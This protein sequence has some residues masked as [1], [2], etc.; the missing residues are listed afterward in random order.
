MKEINHPLVSICCLT[1]NHVNFLDD[2]IN[3]FL[4]QQTD[5][6][7]EVLI[8]DDASTDGTKEL[9]E[10]Y[11]RKYPFR[12][13][14]IYQSINQYS[15]GIKPIFKHVF[16]RARGKYIALCEGDDYWTDPLKLQK[17]VDFLEAN[18]NLMIVS[19]NANILMG[20]NLTE[21]VGISFNCKIK[22][23]NMLRYNM[24]NTVSVV[25]RNKLSSSDYNIL[26]KYP[27]GDWP[28]FCILLQYG[29]GLLLKDFMAVYRIHENGMWSQKEEIEIINALNRIFEQYK[30]DFPQFVKTICAAQKMLNEDFSEYNNIYKHIQRY[31]QL[32]F[33][34]KLLKKLK[35]VY[36]S[37]FFGK[38]H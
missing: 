10:Q 11:E 37:R 15:Q 33:H 18:P 8:H 29:E 27:I 20:D 13:K 2:C 32:N 22:L 5:F 36:S 7:F 35:K 28:L 31:K 38:K 3:G 19:H 24:M 9:L 17:Q 6:E 30:L 4:I 14:I 34:N 26:M 16:P 25:F 21:G 23:K 12:L 1:Y